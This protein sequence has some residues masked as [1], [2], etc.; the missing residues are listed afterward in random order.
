[1]TRPAA[2][3]LERRVR[4]FIYDA[5]TGA[6]VPNSGIPHS[7]AMAM[8]ALARPLRPS[9]L[10]PLPLLHVSHHASSCAPSIRRTDR[11]PSIH[12]PTR[13]SSQRPI[14]SRSTFLAGSKLSPQHTTEARWVSSWSMMCPT[15]TRSRYR[16][17][18][19]LCLRRVHVSLPAAPLSMVVHRAVRFFMRR[20][21]PKGRRKGRQCPTA[22]QP[23]I[24]TS[25]HPNIPTS[26]QPNAHQLPQPYAHRM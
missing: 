15:P 4:C 8:A 6:R 22:Q 19:C 2:F 23:N 7:P 14:P 3:S 9:R 11:A 18:T 20:G 13:P 16:T 24:P 5:P 12:P 1:M 26:Q 17:P 21:G 25:Q 10:I